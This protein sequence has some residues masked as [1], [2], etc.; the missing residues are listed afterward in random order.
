MDPRDEFWKFSLN[1]EMMMAFQ[2]LNPETRETDFDLLKK[3]T[4]RRQKL[5][6]KSK[7]TNSSEE[8]EK[9][10]IMCKINP[11][12]SVPDLNFPYLFTNLAYSIFSTVSRA[13]IFPSLL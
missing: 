3:K 5:Y 13:S 12:N 11:I 4:V 9:Y 6:E 7:G 1:I 2:Y 8:W 10:L